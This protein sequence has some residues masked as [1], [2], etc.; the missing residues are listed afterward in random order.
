MIHTTRGEETPMTKRNPSPWLVAAMS[1]ALA[2][3]ACK[4]TRTTPTMAPP[5]AESRS[6]A[7]AEPA[8]WCAGHA[9]PESMCTKCNPEL[10]GAFKKAGDWCAEHGFPES[11]CPQCNPMKP[12][13]S[14]SAHEGND[15]GAAVSPSAH[16]GHDHGTAV[17]PSAHEGNDHGTAVSPSA[18]EGH[19]HGTA[20]S[21]WC[22][23]HGIP[24]CM[25][26]KCKPELIEA[27]RKVGDW[28]SEH[29][30]PE[31]ACPKCNP[32]KPPGRGS[33]HGDPTLD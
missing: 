2:S 5:P 11:A 27:F 13:A 6:T 21:D 30:F 18:H 17:S 31:S 12:P 29:G 8:D 9:I 33:S 7:V 23:A 20:A 28:C 19:D 16:E 14:R 22:A 1:L 4:G 32:M 15:H 26:T 10:I 25:C 24:E 3:S